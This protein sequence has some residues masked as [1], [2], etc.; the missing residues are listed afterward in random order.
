MFGVVVS[1]SGLLRLEEY[2]AGVLAMDAEI[3]ASLLVETIAVTDALM[4][5]L[6]EEFEPHNKTHATMDHMTSEVSPGFGLITIPLGGPYVEWGFPPHE[7]T[8]R[9]NHVLHWVDQD[10]DHFAWKVAH[11]GYAGDPFVEHAIGRLDLAEFAIG[12]IDRAF[13]EIS[14]HRAAALGAVSL[15]H[16][17][18]DSGVDRFAAIDRARNQFRNDLGTP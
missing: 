16:S 15:F 1:S 14:T 17:L 9:N 10:G 8:A 18:R 7:I 2:A 11:P 12:I 4:A 6:R 5:L 3:A 13:S